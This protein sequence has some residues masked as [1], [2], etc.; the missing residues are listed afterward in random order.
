MNTEAR[1]PLIR[2]IFVIQFQ[3]SGLNVNALLQLSKAVATDVNQQTYFQAKE[4]I[5]Y[6]LDDSTKLAKNEIR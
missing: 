2:E 3:R 5:R 6:F 4:G 1:F